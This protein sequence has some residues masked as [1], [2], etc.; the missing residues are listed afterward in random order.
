MKFVKF[1]SLENIQDGGKF[2]VVAP[3]GL[4][5]L[6]WWSKRGYFSPEVNYGLVYDTEYSSLE[7]VPYDDDTL[8]CLVE[9]I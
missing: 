7:Y 1:G 4:L 5:I 8:V 2:L 3:N 6:C 9:E